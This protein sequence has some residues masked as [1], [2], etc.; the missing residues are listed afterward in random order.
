LGLGDI[1]F[2]AIPDELDRHGYEGWVV[3]EQD[4]L[5]GTGTPAKSARRNREHL[6]DIWA[7]SER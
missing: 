5:P 4:I 7:R 6:R 1:D 3:V 2:R